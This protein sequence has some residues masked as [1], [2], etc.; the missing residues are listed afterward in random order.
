[1]KTSAQSTQS[2]ITKR[3]FS[4]SGF[5][6]RVAGFEVKKAPKRTFKKVLKTVLIGPIVLFR[7]VVLVPLVVSGMQPERGFKYSYSQ[8]SIPPT[9]HSHGN[10]RIFLE[11]DCWRKQQGGCLPIHCIIIALILFLRFRATVVTLGLD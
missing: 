11:I 7:P 1:M 9:H 4:E 2:E 5:L 3:S 10:Q 8:S 6:L